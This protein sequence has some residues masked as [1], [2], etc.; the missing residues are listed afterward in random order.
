MAQ[1]RPQFAFKGRIGERRNQDFLDRHDSQNPA[2][3]TPKLFRR[4][5]KWALVNTAGQ[6]TDSVGKP[7][8]QTPRNRGR[9]IKFT[10]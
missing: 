1:P 6:F 3:I 5:R 2:A 8:S 10:S 4:D 9:P 7:D